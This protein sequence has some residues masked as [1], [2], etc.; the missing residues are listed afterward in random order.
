[1]T[2]CPTCDELWDLRHDELEG[3]PYDELPNWEIA[4]S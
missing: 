4:P 3:C 2:R 1:M